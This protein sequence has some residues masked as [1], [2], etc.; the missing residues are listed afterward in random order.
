MRFKII[1][2]LGKGIYRGII[3]IMLLAKPLYTWMKAASH[4]RQSATMVGRQKARKYTAFV[5]AI[6]VRAPV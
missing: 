6:V 1:K 4:P 3:N 5:L 2:K